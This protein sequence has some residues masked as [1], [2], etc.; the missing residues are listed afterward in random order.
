MKTSEKLLAEIMSALTCN[1]NETAAK[2]IIIEYGKSVVDEC[3]DKAG[4]D[5]YDYVQEVKERIV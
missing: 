5:N 2:N 1:N 3:C 4:R